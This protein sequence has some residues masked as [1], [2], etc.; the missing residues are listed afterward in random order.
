M[1][2]IARRLG[3]VVTLSDKRRES[4]SEVALADVLTGRHLAVAYQP[5]VARRHTGPAQQWRI[6]GVEALI[7]AHSPGGS[8]VRP[9]RLLPAIEKAGLVQP[10]F[11][12]VFVVF[13][14]VNV[15][16]Y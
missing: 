4:T 16:T 2:S 5:I 9:D 14:R 10:L 7:R 12:F 11:M 8:V 1:S 13:Y 3:R 15:L 6:D